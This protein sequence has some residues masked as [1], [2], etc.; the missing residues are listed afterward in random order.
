LG[1]A[2]IYTSIF[3]HLVL[4]QK[5]DKRSAERKLKVKKSSSPPP[6]SS[7]KKETETEKEKD[8]KSN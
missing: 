6:P 1:I 5:A 3:G 7:P 2:S 8:T 4:R